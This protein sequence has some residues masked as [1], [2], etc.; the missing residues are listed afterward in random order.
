MFQA[1]MCIMKCTLLENHAIFQNEARK[2]WVP[3]SP[4]GFQGG[5][6]QLPLGGRPP[7]K[8]APWAVTCYH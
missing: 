7:K 8:N 2:P 4:Q 3:E 6:T 1:A 5:L